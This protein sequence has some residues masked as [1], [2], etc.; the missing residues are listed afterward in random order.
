MSEKG[1]KTVYIQCGYSPIKT[2]HITHQ[3]EKEWWSVYHNVNNTVM[4]VGGIRALP[5]LS[6]FQYL[7]LL[8]Y[9][10]NN[11]EL[12]VKEEYFPLSTAVLLITQF[13]LITVPSQSL[14][15]LPKSSAPLLASGGFS[16]PILCLL[17][18]LRALLSSFNSDGTL[19]PPPAGVCSL[20]SHPSWAPHTQT[21]DTVCVQHLVLG[22]GTLAAPR[23]GQTQAAAATVVHPT[24]VGTH[25]RGGMAGGGRGGTEDRRWVVAGSGKAREGR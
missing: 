21:S 4:F 10:F 15:P 3:T 7:G 9:Y 18:P 16:H 23:G 5:L 22:A 25:C 2:N 19:R 11:E 12:K 8:L 13:P 17:S 6:N 14:L 20:A 24:F 1:Q